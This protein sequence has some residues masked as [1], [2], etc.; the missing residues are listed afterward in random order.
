MS[1]VQTFLFISSLLPLLAFRGEC[2]PS[3]SLE[4]SPATATTSSAGAPSGPDIDVRIGTHLDRETSQVGTR[5]VYTISLEWEGQLGWVNVEAPELMLPDEV[6]QTEVSIRTRSTA[7]ETGPRGIKQFVYTLTAK[8][9]G[10]FRIP[11]LQVP[12]HTPGQEEPV[13]LQA[14]EVSG[15]VIARVPSAGEKIQAFLRDSGWLV[16]GGGTVALAAILVFLLQFK[17]KPAPAETGPDL[18]EGVEEQLKRAEALQASG[19]DREYYLAL[20]KTLAAAL[21]RYH[22][23]TIGKL[24]DSRDWENL[25]GETSR[26]M[27]DLMAEIADRKF[28]PDRPR[29]EEAARSLKRTRAMVRSLQSKTPEKPNL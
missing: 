8:K 4:P 23:R 10:D 27:K 22:G 25:P 21:S 11:S 14:P 15:E 9:E 24:N 12:I 16:V 29:P 1:R 28:R 6:E 18:W 26:E 3:I 7:G 19:A 17:K 5:I 20:E 13:L 2:Q